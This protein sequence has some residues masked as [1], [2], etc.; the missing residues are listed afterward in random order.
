MK[1]KTSK[2]YL[3]DL[4]NYLQMN[5]KQLANNIGLP[6][7]DKIYNVLHLKNGVSDSLARTITRKY[8]NISYNW[9]KTGTGDMLKYDENSS[10]NAGINIHN[11]GK[12]KT[13]GIHIIQNQSKEEKENR[14]MD[15]YKTLS[16]EYDKF[17]NV[18]MQKDEYIERIIRKSNERNEENM[19]R[20][21]RIFD[22]HEKIVSKNQEQIDKMITILEK[23]IEGEK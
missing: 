7:A 2:H 11:V 17:R 3:L 1:G 4:L 8:N 21:D 10:N 14:I 19:M 12:N 9:L 6:R 22:I 13:N 23:L 20:I 18:Q 15:Y 5:P 16:E